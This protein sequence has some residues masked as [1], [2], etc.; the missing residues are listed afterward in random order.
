MTK[1]LIFVRRYIL[2][3]TILL[4]AGVLRF[5]GIYPGY[6]EHTDEA[7]YSSAVTMILK[8]NLDPGRY[9][10]PAG[11]PLLHTLIFKL[12]FIP[13]YWAKFYFQNLG[14]IVDGLIKVP[15]G[16]DDYKRIFSL[17]IFGPREINVM[18]WGRYVTAF[19]GVTVVLFTYL[20]AKKVFGKTVGLTSAFLVAV[21]FRQVLN[22]HLGLPDIYNAFFLLITAYFLYKIIESPKKINYFFAGLFN[23]LYFSIKFQTFG[24]APLFIA[25]VIATWKKTDS[26]FKN[27]ISVFWS[28]K[29]FVSA[30]TSFFV[31]AFLNPYLFQKFEIFKSVQ[32]YQLAK[33][34]LG[35]NSI[36]VF[37]LSYLYNIGIG[38]WI[39]IFVIF[40]VFVCLI[41]YFKKSLILI[42]FVVQFMMMFVYLSRGGFYTRNF[43]TITPILLIF[44]AVSVKFI[45]DAIPH[46]TKF[47]WFYG[48]SICVLILLISIGNI[49]NSI[50]VTK[51]YRQ[52]WNKKILSM[53]VAKNIPSGSAV[54]AHPDTPLP[55]ENVTRN[56]YEP[57]TRFS[58]DEFIS[59]G[60]TYAISNSSWTTNSFY[61]WMNS[62]LSQVK[63]LWTKP[64]AVLED[65]YPALALRE[66][67]QFNIYE[68]NNSWQAPDVDFL[69]AKLPMYKVVSKNKELTYDF[70]SSTQDW[71]KSGKY[72][73]KDDN[74][75]WEKGS[76]IVYEQSASVPSLRWESSPVLVDD[77]QGFEVDYKIKSQAEKTD[78]R[79]GYLF[80]SFYRNITDAKDGNNRLGLRLSERATET[81]GW[82]SKDLIGL[83]PVETKYMTINFY[84]YSPAISAVGLDDI[85][86]Y[87]A[88]V[89][90]DLGG[91]RINPVKIDQNNIFLNSHGNL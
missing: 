43:V 57:D 54:S 31:M 41:K 58:V 16:V 82:L 39:S 59:Q 19:F 61:W 35:A 37:P 24:F 66:L 27:L 36:N 62:N 6:P 69:V 13:F 65:S 81:N 29:L 22:S 89:I 44:A 7:G 76:L 23:A 47:K 85:V 64:L 40:G 63:N 5:V 10:Y 21:N 88:K 28:P 53:W 33:Y 11:L 50:L 12:I 32:S 14:A 51:E 46:L 60:S 71:K 9:D 75:G 45:F 25:H 3:I 83:I 49:K 68:I 2:I 90:Q 56:P 34:G 8:D 80:V 72:W 30:L 87:R 84:N 73:S 86:V 26:F 70:D 67:G 77:W 55:I 42:L 38:P 18:Y 78:V 17:D 91:V 52:D 20:L 15:L 79:T 1:I 4:I 48:F 74:L